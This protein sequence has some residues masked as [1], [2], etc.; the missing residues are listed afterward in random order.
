MRRER[1]GGH[2]LPARRDGGPAERIAARHLRCAPTAVRALS[3]G[4]QR[5]RTA[6]SR[7]C[8]RLGAAIAA[9]RRCGGRGVAGRRFAGPRKLRRAS[10]ASGRRRARPSDGCQP[11]PALSS[12]TRWPRGGARRGTAS[13]S[14]SAPRSPRAADAAGAALRDAALPRAGAA[15]GRRP[16]NR[17][18]RA[19]RARRGAQRV[20]AIAP[21]FRAAIAAV[22]RRGG[23]ARCPDGATAPSLPE[24]AQFAARSD[25]NPSSR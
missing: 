6:E 22:R 1:L 12:S 24:A 20:A 8:L 15:A 2:S 3:A 16:A 25:E 5:S 18:A 14:C 9:V 11:W 19:C 7:Q 4:S 10:G 23:R 21:W 17:L 13:S